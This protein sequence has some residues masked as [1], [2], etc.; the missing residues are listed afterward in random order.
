MLS[1]LPEIGMGTVCRTTPRCLGLAT[2]VVNFLQLGGRH[3]KVR[4]HTATV[5]LI[6]RSP[7]R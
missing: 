6:G 3:M 4:H 1:E 5:P 2:S 7:R